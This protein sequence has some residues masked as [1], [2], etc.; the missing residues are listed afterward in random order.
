ML[1]PTR[2]KA[3]RKVRGRKSYPGIRGQR[4]LRKKLVH[5]KAPRKKA[6]RKKLGFAD[7]ELEEIESLDKLDDRLQALD[8]IMGDALSSV[9]GAVSQAQEEIYQ[10]INALRQESFLRTERLTDKKDEE[11]RTAKV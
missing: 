4:G 11:E 3:T 1:K 10:A 2:K 9:G 7:L 5:K 8:R 6:T